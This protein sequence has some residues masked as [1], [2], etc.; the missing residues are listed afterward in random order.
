MP[1]YVTHTPNSSNHRCLYAVNGCSLCSYLAL[2]HLHVISLQPTHRLAVGWRA[3]LGLLPGPLV[4]SNTLTHCYGFLPLFL[5]VTCGQVIS[6]HIITNLCNWSQVNV[7]AA[8]CKLTHLV[9]AI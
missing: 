1:K 5:R 6:L 9:L 7:S 3:P 8:D 4:F 2:L